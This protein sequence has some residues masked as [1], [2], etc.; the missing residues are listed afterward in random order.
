MEPSRGFFDVGDGRGRP[1][2]HPP[3]LSPRKEL[4]GPRPSPLQVSRE[5]RKIKKPPPPPPRPSQD[6]LHH[7]VALPPPENMQ[8]VIIYSVSPKVIHVEESNFMSTVQRLTGLSPGPAATA[9]GDV[10]PA[11]RLAS[12]ERTSPTEGDRS[13]VSVSISDEDIMSIL[14]ELELGQIPG[15]LSPAPATL[16]PLP[17]AFFS[18]AVEPQ[19][20][21]SFLQ[22]LSPFWHSPSSAL[23]SAP[24]IFSPHPSSVDLFNLLGEF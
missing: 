7:L 17:A 21:T 9:S 12:I 10:S 24:I 16:P 19:Q 3:R 8:P 20:S 23:F 4:V 14:E 5:S 22:D 15:I 11:A 13:G 2:Q 1:P 18:P 6:H